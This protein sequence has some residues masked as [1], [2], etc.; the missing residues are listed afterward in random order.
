VRLSAG[1]DSES[2]AAP[3]AVMAWSSPAGMVSSVGG[4]LRQ[5]ATPGAFAR[6]ACV[7]TTGQAQWLLV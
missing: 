5:A 6:I 3:Q 4:G 1:P 7:D 2:V